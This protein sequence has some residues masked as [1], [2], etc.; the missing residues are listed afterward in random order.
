M[1]YL[2]ALEFQE[3]CG[4]TTEPGSRRV[5]TAF[6]IPPV[7]GPVLRR[8]HEL[9]KDIRLGNCHPI[10]LC[11]YRFRLPEELEDGSLLVIRRRNRRHVRVVD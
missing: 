5:K 4:V 11:C 9:G 8:K 6:H 1:P 7:M 10:V 3:P 2:T